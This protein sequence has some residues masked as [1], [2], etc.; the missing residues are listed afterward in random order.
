MEPRNPPRCTGTAEDTA[1][2]SGAGDAPGFSAMGVARS[3]LGYGSAVTD[4]S[5]PST[6]RRRVEGGEAEEAGGSTLPRL[7]P[8]GTARG[9]AAGGRCTIA[10]CVHL[11]GLNA[12]S[13][14]GVFSMHAG[15]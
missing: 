13:P 4:L 9:L 11:R 15:S 14:S 7:E 8:C 3:G 12:K 10:T 1:G 2:R 5:M 6:Y